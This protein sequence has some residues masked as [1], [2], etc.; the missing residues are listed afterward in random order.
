MTQ[1]LITRPADDAA[2]M[3]QDVAALGYV[4]VICP[5]FAVQPQPFIPPVAPP[6]TLVVT[7]QH[8]VP[9]LQNG[10]TA[11]DFPRNLTCLAVGERTGQA[12]RN[13]GFTN[14]RVAGGDV[15]A[16][17]ALI[18][19]QP[20]VKWGKIFYVRGDVVAHDL[21]VTLGAQ[22]YHIAEQVAYVMA[23][24]VMPPQLAQFWQ[25]SSGG[26][27]TLFSVRAADAF[28]RHIRQIQAEDNAAK[29]AVLCFAPGVLNSVRF[30]PWRAMH[31]SVQP[32]M[33]CM[34]DA[35]A[36]FAATSAFEEGQNERNS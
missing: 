34:L 35:L 24:Q 23:E 27:V 28:A 12:L 36:R 13:A 16:L 18:L 31:V 4:P 20:P 9:W 10:A 3:A 5:L 30:L 25:Q 8:A 11:R 2:R 22:G 17:L 15:S 7:S 29:H 26:V 32:R 19:A 1:L 21:A 14:V 33:R 6:D